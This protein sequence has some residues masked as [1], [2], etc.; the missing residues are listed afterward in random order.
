MSP[1]ASC[2][3]RYQARVGYYKTRMRTVQIGSEHS[4]R[5]DN[6]GNLWP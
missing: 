3:L 5:L 1:Y 4:W 2:A 6:D